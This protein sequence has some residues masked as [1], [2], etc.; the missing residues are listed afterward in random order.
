MSFLQ[1]KKDKHGQ[2]IYP[3]DVCVRLHRS[4][5]GTTELQFVS[6]DKPAWGGEGSKG[7]YGRFITPSGPSSIKYSS[8]VFAFDPIGKRK[9][10]SP[11]VK[12]VV[13]EFYES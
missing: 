1:P 5:Q 13:S 11:Q 12:Q 10:N 2:F 9:N 3:G 8:V 7:E 4:S 6:F